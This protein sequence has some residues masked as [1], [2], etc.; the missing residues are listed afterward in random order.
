MIEDRIGSENNGDGVGPP[1]R[2]MDVIALVLIYF[3]A[4]LSPV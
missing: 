4:I 1:S 3:R 2:T